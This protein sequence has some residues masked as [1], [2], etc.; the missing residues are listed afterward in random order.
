MVKHPPP[1]T[2]A[3]VP[4]AILN[5]R[6]FSVRNPGRRASLGLSF[7]T[8]ATDVAAE[9]RLWDRAQSPG[10]TVNTTILVTII[11][12]V[13]VVTWHQTCLVERES[14]QEKATLG[15]LPLSGSRDGR[16]LPTMLAPWMVEPCGQ[17]LKSPQGLRT[18]AP[19]QPGC[20]PQPS[21]ER[22]CGVHRPQSWTQTQ[23]PC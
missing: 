19:Q 11:F 16:D 12:A 6:A 21:R 13:A 4:A 3:Q 10:D 20:L 7:P 22:D 2:E 8:C 15:R 9:R 14:T 17:T 18:D 1:W 5:E 23:C